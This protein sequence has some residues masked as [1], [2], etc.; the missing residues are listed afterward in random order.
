MSGESF[1]SLTV[2]FIVQQTVPRARYCRSE[3][4]LLLTNNYKQEI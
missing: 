1:S 2:G 3:R 4:S